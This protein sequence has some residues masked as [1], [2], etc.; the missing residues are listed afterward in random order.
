[1]I[2]EL[3]LPLPPDLLY[4]ENRLTAIVRSRAA[5]LASKLCRFSIS[6]NLAS[7]QTA[8]SRFSATSRNTCIKLINI[9]NQMNTKNIPLYH[10]FLTA[11][12]F[13]YIKL[14]CC[15]SIAILSL[16]ARLSILSKHSPLSAARD[17]FIAWFNPK[18]WSR[19]LRSK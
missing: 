1:M 9:V 8:R 3:T 18:S 11:L 7:S 15:R 12:S 16:R 2:P 10:S 4:F 19:V 17:S 6:V 13:Y 5:F 14:T